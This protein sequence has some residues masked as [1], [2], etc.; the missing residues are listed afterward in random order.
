MERKWGK[1]EARW[2][3]LQWMSIDIDKEKSRSF[4][5]EPG[6]KNNYCCVLF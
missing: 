3:T 1:P 4:N 5:N 6:Q 2:A